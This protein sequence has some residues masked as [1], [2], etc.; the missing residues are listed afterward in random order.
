MARGL[1]VDLRGISAER[2]PVMLLGGLNLVRTVGLAS[3]PAIVASAEADPPV[4]ASRY[5]KGRLMLPALENRAAAADALLAAGEELKARFGERL[6]LFYGN[7][8]LLDLVQEYADA[9]SSVFL[10]LLN[11]ADVGRALIDKERFATLARSRGVLVPRKLEWQDLGGFD[12]PVVLKPKVKFSW[13]HSPIFLRLLDGAGKALVFQSGKAVLA[14]PMANQL[15]DALLVQ[16][17][18]AG[19]DTNLWSFHGYADERSNLLAYFIGRKV[20][21][22]PKHTG[23]S[24]FLELAHDE[25]LAAFGRDVAARLPLKGV[26]KIDLKKDARSGRLYVLEVN[27]RF[28]L[29]HYLGAR[30]GINIPKIAYEYLRLGKRPAGSPYRTRYRWLA[31][32]ND[33]RAYRALAARGELGF[34]RWLA[35]LLS[36]PKVYDLFSWRDPLPWIVVYRKRLGSRLQ[37]LWLCTAS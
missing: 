12:G 23:V 5:T 36:R 17:Y 18:I 9:L 33:Y 20:R 35:S 13:E 31:F 32:Q 30:N 25:E 8:D 37:R 10:L 7:D 16:E 26:F 21:T 27:A 2:P 15:R 28:N 3:L 22:W 14:H 29:W 34:A 19:D 6:P 4:L 11:D 24:T 1:S